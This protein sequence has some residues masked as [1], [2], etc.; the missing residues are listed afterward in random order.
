MR[1]EEASVQIFAKLKINNQ[2]WILETDAVLCTCT[3]ETA[4][5]MNDAK[6]T[7]L[8]EGRASAK[9]YQHKRFDTVMVRIA[10]VGAAGSGKTS[11]LARIVDN[12]FGDPRATIGVDFILKRLW[13]ANERHAKLQLYDIAGDDRYASNSFNSLLYRAD[14]A[15]LVYDVTSEESKKRLDRW[16][17][18][19]E[20]DTPDS[21]LIALVGNKADKFADSTASDSDWRF[22]RDKAEQFCAGNRYYFT[23]AKTGQN[24][25]LVFHDLAMAV[26]DSRLARGMDEGDDDAVELTKAKTKSAKNKCCS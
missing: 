9:R 21:C 18:R 3:A 23:S 12:S 15:V 26:L 4:V 17:R 10:V 24:C 6:F 5:Y 25:G 11:L 8:N 22:L 13:C 7:F 16:K 20:E 1:S 19:M 2:R 14:A